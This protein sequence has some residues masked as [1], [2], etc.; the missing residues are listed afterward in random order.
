M[1]R[2]QL[3]FCFSVPAC[4]T[5]AESL[6]T[7]AHSQ[8]SAEA[9]KKAICEFLCIA[10]SEP[11]RRDPAPMSTNAMRVRALKTRNVAETLVKL[12]TPRSDK[13]S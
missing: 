10:T 11:R 1:S 12:Y 7:H 4:S 2:L 6:G 13:Y 9:R 3:C 5:V 8:C